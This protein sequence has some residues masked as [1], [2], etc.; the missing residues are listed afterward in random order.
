[1]V[2]WRGPSG[3]RKASTSDPMLL[4]VFLPLVLP[5][6]HGA[7]MVLGEKL[8]SKRLV[9]ATAG[10]DQ[11]QLKSNQFHGNNQTQ[12]INMAMAVT[13]FGQF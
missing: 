9:C 6:K 11:A 1:M 12:N 4:T 13:H 8:H 2:R 3:V 10:F 5:Q 7:V